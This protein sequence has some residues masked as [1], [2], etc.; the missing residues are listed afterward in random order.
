MHARSKGFDRKDAEEAI[1]VLKLHSVQP[2]VW[3]DHAQFEGNLLHYATFGS[4]KV[5]VDKS[6]HHYKNYRYTLDL[7]T[8]ELGI[9]F[10]W[11]GKLTPVLGQDRTLTAQ[12]Y[13]SE[14]SNSR[15][16]AYGK[17][18]AKAILPNFLL[19][20]RRGF[21]VPENHQYQKYVFPDGNAGY[22]FRRYG[23][24]EDADIYGLHNL[25]NPK[26]IEQLLRTGGTAIVYTHLG[27]RPADKMGK[28]KHIPEM[29]LSSLHHLREKYISKSLM[30]T[31]TSELLEYLVIRDHIEVSKDR[32]LINF[33]SD[34]VRFKPLTL[35]DL[36]GKKFSFRRQKETSGFVVAIDGKKIDATIARHDN[37]NIFTVDFS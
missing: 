5:I 18:L 31:S 21:N 12:S 8:Q 10:F 20:Y 29:T 14:T 19:T 11:D 9:R 26:S 35:R 34:G 33:K 1:Q 4:R 23:T 27:K 17:T 16:K 24:W 2:K 36:S 7:I 3:I 22:I 32:R 6:G 30:L 25:I 15:I 37:Q 28:D 13:F